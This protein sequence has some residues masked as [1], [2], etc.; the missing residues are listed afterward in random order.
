MCLKNLFGYYHYKRLF[1]FGH[2]INIG[3][4][5]DGKKCKT[6]FDIAGHIY[7]TV[8]LYDANMCLFKSDA[9]STYKYLHPAFTFI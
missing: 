4:I 7:C 8:V 2:I 6:D 9:Y 3:Q 1:Y 5:F